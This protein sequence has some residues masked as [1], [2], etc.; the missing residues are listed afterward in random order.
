MELLIN[1]LMF[2]NSHKVRKQLCT[3]LGLINLME[4]NESAKPEEFESIINCLKN[5]LGDLD[6]ETRRL[7]VLL[8]DNYTGKVTFQAAGQA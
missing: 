1:E 4:G 6:E 8:H 2:I 5:A 3:C 7:S